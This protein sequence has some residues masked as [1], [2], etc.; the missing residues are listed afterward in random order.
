M[1][2][3]KQSALIVFLYAEQEE[4]KFE[5]RMTENMGR[6][7]FARTNLVRNTR[8]LQYAGNLLPHEEGVKLHEKYSRDHTIA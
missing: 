4:G 8:V 6:G 5:I 7:V 2:E 3:E 1:E